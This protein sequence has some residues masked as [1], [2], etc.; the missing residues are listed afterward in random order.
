[1]LAIEEAKD[2]PD[3]QQGRSLG[4]LLYMLGYTAYLQ[5][6]NTLRNR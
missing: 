1:M 5:D 6:W 3:Y 4:I 2:L